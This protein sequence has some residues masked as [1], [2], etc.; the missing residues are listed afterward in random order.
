MKSCYGCL[1]CDRYDVCKVGDIDWLCENVI[2]RI[3]VVMSFLI[4]FNS[5]VFESIEYFMCSWFYG[6][7]LF[8]YEIDKEGDVGDVVVVFNWIYYLGWFELLNLLDKD[9]L[10]DLIVDLNE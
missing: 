9:F 3:W 5:E 6:V 10:M 4:Y 2:E 7:W 8:K 1:L